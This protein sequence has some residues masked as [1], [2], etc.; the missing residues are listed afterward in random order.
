MLGKLSDA[1]DSCDNERLCK[2]LIEMV[3][4]FKP[5]CEIRD[6]LYKDKK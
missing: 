6:I 4:G 3:P 2:L 1:I 5:K